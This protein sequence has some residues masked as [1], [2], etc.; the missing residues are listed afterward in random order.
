MQILL[1][2]QKSYAMKQMLFYF[3]G[4]LVVLL[5]CDKTD[6]SDPYVSDETEAESISHEMIELGEKL[7]DPYT[8][9]NV[10]KAIQTLY[11]TKAGRI[12]LKPTD[13]YV[14][15]LPQDDD[16]LAVLQEMGVEFLDHPMDYAIV[17]DGDYYHDPDIEEEEITWQYCVVPDE[18]I[19]PRNIKYEILDYCYI[20][21]NDPATRAADGEID[22]AAV[23]KEAYRLTGNES[24]YDEMSTKSG[25]SKP[26]GRITIVDENANGGKP[27]GLPGVK[28]VCNSFVKFSSTYT[29]R[30]GYYKISKSFSSRPRYRIMFKNKSGFAIG[31]NWILVPASTSTLGKGPKEGKDFTIDRNSDWKLFCRSVITCAAYDYIATCNE[32]DSGVTP[33][34]GSVRIWMFKGLSSSSAP[35]LKHGAMIDNTI[36]GKYLGTFA[37]I[38]KLFLPDITIGTK[39]AGSFADIYSET[40]HEMAHASHYSKVGNSY[41][42]KYIKFV[43]KEFVLHGKEAYGVDGDE[44][45]GYCEVGEM[46]AY[47]MQNKLYNERYGGEMPV[48]G[49]N[50]WF[51]PQ[52]FSYLDERGVGK[53]KICR[54][55]T[56][57]VKDVKSLR[58]KLISTYPEKADIINQAFERYG[59]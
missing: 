13:I 43:L 27:F 33:P 8:V 57:E 32:F 53:D 58:S 31:F 41:W 59:K 4:A 51:H 39:D 5:A 19:F 49:S 50:F 24:L 40:I 47:Y 15:F 36:I 9:A 2:Q 25:A 30:D 3:V 55:L 42:D 16:Q 21:E 10:T 34:P 23:E 6:V 26:E 46:W 35:M 1:Y 14:R 29:D 7:D 54:V 44:D 22:W 18:F 45:C 11:P 20:S 38:V 12:E 17:K 56:S 52:I 37:G 48:A 28:I